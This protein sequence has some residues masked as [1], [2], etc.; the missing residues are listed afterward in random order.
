LI[1]R[2]CSLKTG[3]D[4]HEAV[5]LNTGNVLV[6]GGNTAGGSPL[7]DTELYNPSTG[8]WS[9]RGNLITGQTEFTATLLTSGKVLAAGGLHDTTTLSSAEVY[10]P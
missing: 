2:N 1:P 3:R 7:S 4:S 8:V 6:A 5:L 9:L 10:Q